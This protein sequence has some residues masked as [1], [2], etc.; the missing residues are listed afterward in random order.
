MD[1][2]T[3]II[4]ED[5]PLLR[6][7]LADALIDEGYDVMEAGN[8]LEAIA[9]LANA[10]F[11]AVI[12]DID[13]PGGLNGLELARIVSSTHHDVAL[14]IASGGHRLGPEQLPDR[15]RFVSKPYDLQ[16]MTAMLKAMTETDTFDDASSQ[17]LQAA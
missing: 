13:M 5:E 7:A 17:A 2:R 4:V 12:T 14:I 10:A 3:V 16:N 9:L 1:Q 8:A 11:A 6:M 15:A